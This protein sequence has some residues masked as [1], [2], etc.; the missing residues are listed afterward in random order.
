[1]RLQKYIANSGYCSRRKAELLIEEGRVS[2]NGEIINTQGVKIK[3]GD[4]VEI[5]GVALEG[6]KNKYLLLYKPTGVIT[7]VSD[8]RNRKTVLDLIEGVGE[9]IYPVGRLDKDTSGLLIL[10]NDGTLTQRLTHPSFEVDKTYEVYLDCDLDE[11]EQTLIRSGVV[12]EDRRVEVKILMK[13]GIK[14]Y[15]LT[16]HEGRNRIV[17]KIFESLGHEVVRLKRTKYA[18]LTLKGLKPSEWR[19]LNDEEVERLK[20]I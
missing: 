8:D 5:D 2:V 17:R 6:E 12:I 11:E 1:M 14:K 15:Q 7:T 16:I 3:E 4:I 20:K 9:R 18:F 13:L 19:F 10:T